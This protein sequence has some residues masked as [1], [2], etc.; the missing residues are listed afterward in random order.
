MTGPSF[1]CSSELDPAAALICGEPA[2]ALA[3]GRMGALYR[4]AREKD[5][6]GVK[7]MQRQWLAA[8]N[9]ACRPDRI[10]TRFP[11]L[12]NNLAECL[13]AFTE[14]QIRELARGI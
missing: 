11:V 6:E 10:D 8:R 3:D 4:M 12:R 5:S 7:A 13:M 2:L 14:R 9:R 1:D